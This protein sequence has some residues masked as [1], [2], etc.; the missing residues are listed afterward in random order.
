MMD[1]VYRLKLKTGKIRNAVLLK[2]DLLK[3]RVWKLRTD[4]SIVF[5]GEVKEAIKLDSVLSYLFLYM[6][7]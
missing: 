7:I 1:E 5:D 3:E 2:N 4:S 6:N